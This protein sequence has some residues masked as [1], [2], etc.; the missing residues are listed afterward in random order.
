MESFRLSLSFV[1]ESMQ[2][3]TMELCAK[4]RILTKI[5]LQKW[6]LGVAQLTKIEWPYFA[7]SFLKKI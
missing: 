2:D 1:T 6:Y 4:H 7:A 5:K 3:H